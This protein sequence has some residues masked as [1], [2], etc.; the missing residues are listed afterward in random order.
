VNPGARSDK[1]SPIYGMPILDADKARRVI[2]LKRSLGVGF[3][4]TQNELFFAPNTMMLFGD[5]KKTILEL[6]ASVKET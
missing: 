1:D 3:A 2:I 6:I 5:A 4:G